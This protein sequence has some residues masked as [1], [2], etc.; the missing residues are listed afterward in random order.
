MGGSIT[1]RTSHGASL[2]L[3]TWSHWR[4]VWGRAAPLCP[5]FPA[6][7]VILALPQETMKGDTRQLNGEEDTSRREDS[8]L[9]NG[10][11]SDQSSDSKDAPSPPILEAISTPEIRGGRGGRGGL[12]C[13]E[14]GWA[15]TGDHS[16]H[17]SLR[18][19]S[20]Q[21]VGREPHTTAL[22][23]LQG[24]EEDGGR[25]PGLPIFLSPQL[26]L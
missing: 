23:K 9:T 12:A 2:G 10:G 4:E 15:G 11:C 6:T 26:G 21:V 18:A 14:D 17:T 8:I 25:A 19:G 13:G 7:L 5:C 1:L 22:G 3:R 16:W 20:R 24:R